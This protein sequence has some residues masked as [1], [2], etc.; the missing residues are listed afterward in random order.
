MISYMCELSV[1]RSRLTAAGL[2]PVTPPGHS[3]RALSIDK[4]LLLRELLKEA[5][6]PLVSGIVRAVEENDDLR[7]VVRKA[8]QIYDLW[9]L[10]HQDIVRIFVRCALDDPE[11]LQVLHPVEEVI[12]ARLDAVLDLFENGLYSD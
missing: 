10:N 8:L 12:H 2:F 7:E 11:S 9:L 4:R 6:D 1:V 5:T 3:S